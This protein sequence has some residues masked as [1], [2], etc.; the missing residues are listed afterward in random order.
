M[1]ENREST[2][3]IIQHIGV[4]G[5]YKNKT[6]EFNIVKWADGKPRFDIRNFEKDGHKSKRGITLSAAELQKLKEL[7]DS[8]LA[9]Q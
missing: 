9:E 5:D 2:L 8:V 6:K 3:E 7:I 1:A 4:I